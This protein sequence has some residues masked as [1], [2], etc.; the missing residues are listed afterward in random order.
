MRFL[1]LT[2]VRDVMLK[3]ANTDPC[4]RELGIKICGGPPWVGLM[5]GGNAELPSIARGR[6]AGVRLRDGSA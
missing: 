2:E 3:P 1:P 4:L 6:R 5:T